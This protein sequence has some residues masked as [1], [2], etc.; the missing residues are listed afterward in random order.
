MRLGMSGQKDIELRNSKQMHE[1]KAKGNYLVINTT[2]QNDLKL[3][4][5][6]YFVQ[7]DTEEMYGIQ[8]V[9]WES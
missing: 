6:K 8:Y 1:S 3:L 9:A 4:G 7:F 2:V 5:L